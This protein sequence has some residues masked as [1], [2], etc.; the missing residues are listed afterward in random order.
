MRNNI[1][2]AYNKHIWNYLINFDLKR[3]E[4]TEKYP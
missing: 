1:H 2:I 4:S 3:P